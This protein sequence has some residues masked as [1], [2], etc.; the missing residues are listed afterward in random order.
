VVGTSGVG[1]G[2]G[3]PSRRST[4]RTLNAAVA[5]IAT[6]ALAGCGGSTARQTG[7]SGNAAPNGSASVA[8]SNSVA[9][10][11]VPSTKGNKTKPG[12][13]GTN[14]TGS[15]S[16]GGGPVPTY[17]G[18]GVLGGASSKPLNP[19]LP[20]IRLGYVIPN[21]AGVAAATGTNPS[22]MG[23]PTKQQNVS[24]EI[25]EALIGWAN[26]T[27][28]VGGRK[29]E[30]KGYSI[31]Q[32]AT[33]DTKAADCKGM[34]EDDHRQV[35]IDVQVYA[36]PTGWSCFAQHHVDYFGAVNTVDAAY[37]KSTAPYI[38]TTYPSIKRQMT[39]FPGALKKAGYFDNNKLG[40][41]FDEGLEA[42]YKSFLQPAL[43]AVGITDI[44]AR[45]LSSDGSQASNAELAFSTENVKRVLIFTYD[46]NYLAFTNQAESQ[47]YHPIYG[48]PDY[49]SSAVVAGIFGSPSQNANSYAVS[50]L[51]NRCAIA[52]NGSENCKNLSAP[53]SN[54]NLTPGGIA[55]NNLLT[56]LTGHDYSNASQSGDVDAFHGSYCNNFLLWLSAAR[57]VGSG[58]TPSNVDQGLRKVGTSYQSA[59]Q[60]ATDFSTGR[61]DGASEYRIGRFNTTCSCFVAASG[62]FPLPTS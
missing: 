35:I 50:T 19:Q 49:Q 32:T 22:Q 56:K 59:I 30:A 5:V 47:Q 11:P 34:T 14:T 26:A 48:F 33:A 28:G 38:N 42:D 17:S 6:I 12:T 37:L 7:S 60:Y 52:N 20:A 53:N 3:K 57:E 58:W 27:G 16:S 21:Y 1:S 15:T 24:R 46:V 41:L 10:L 45:F 8:G 55:C 36:D 4:N 43:K 18:G 40:I 61:S 2:S 31:D 51:V 13:S 29:I 25:M 9:P 23:D 62:W 44:D 54:S 39:S